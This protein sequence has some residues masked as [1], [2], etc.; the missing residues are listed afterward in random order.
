MNF[1][2][3]FYDITEENFKTLWDRKERFI[4]IRNPPYRWNIN[5]QIETVSYLAMG[6]YIYK[7]LKKKEVSR[8]LFRSAGN[9]SLPV[10]AN[11]NKS[12]D[13]QEKIRKITED[14]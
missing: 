8:K 2:K 11:W 4:M 12:L 3:V 5:E 14:F 10:N 7:W 13:L 9:H 6:K 1:Q